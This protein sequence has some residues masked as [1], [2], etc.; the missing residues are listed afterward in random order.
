MPALSF[1]GL[2]LRAVRN[3]TAFQGGSALPSTSGPI[4]RSQPSQWTVSCRQMASMWPRCEVGRV[5]MTGGVASDLL[6]IRPSAISVPVCSER[7]GQI[8]P[9]HGTWSR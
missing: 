6:D 7:A 1:W 3:L 5:A 2:G 4:V 8:D 9:G